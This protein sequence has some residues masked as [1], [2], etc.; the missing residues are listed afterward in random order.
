MRSIVQSVSVQRDS[1]PSSVALFLAWQY[2]RTPL[3][4][5]GSPFLSPKKRLVCLTTKVSSMAEDSDYELEPLREGAEFTV[6]RGRERGN[7]MPILAV[8]VAAEQPSPECLRRLEQE[9]LLATELDAAWAVQPLAL[10]RYRGRA[11]LILK[12]PGGE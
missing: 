6:Y 5:F 10:T 2:H 4:D 8:A 9:Y 12:D 1:I 3:Q 7:Q 11:V